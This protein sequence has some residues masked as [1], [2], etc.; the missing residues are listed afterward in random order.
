[1]NQLSSDS[2]DTSA[3]WKFARLAAVIAFI[4]GSVLTLSG[5]N[6]GHRARL[7]SELL[8]HEARQPASRARVIVHGTPEEISTIAARH[9]LTVVRQMADSAVLI[10]NSAELT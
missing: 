2:R 5:S 10:A 7:S 4:A 8:A 9:H 6:L 1:M 3:R